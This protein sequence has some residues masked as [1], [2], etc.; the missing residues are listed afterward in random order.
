MDKM[1]ILDGKR[2]VGIYLQLGV[3]FIRHNIMVALYK[4]YLDMGEL[5]PPDPEIL[6]FIVLPAMEHIAYYHQSRRQ[7]TGNELL[8][9]EKVFLD[10]TSG[11][12]N[13]G[14]AEMRCLP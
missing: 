5:P 8:Q 9:P 13:T 6:Y 14:F 3:Y 7:I 11:Y 10:N 1:D 4:V 12:G 2:S